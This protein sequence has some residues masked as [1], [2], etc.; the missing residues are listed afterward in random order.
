MIP[1][2][3]FVGKSGSGKTTLIE[4]IISGLRRR[5]WRVATIKHSRHG[6]DIDREGKD[7]WRHRKAGAKMTVMA[8]PEQIAIIE[9]AEKDFEIQD[10]RDKYIHDVD[11]ILTEGFKGN[12]YPKI[13]VFRASLN[14]DMLCSGNDNLIAIASD[15]QIGLG[16]V[17]CIDINNAEDITQLIV[18]LFLNTSDKE[19]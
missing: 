18:D 4:K 16:G 3:S 11:I 6:F 8:S 7:T 2:V 10:L 1:V 14:R 9:D 15:K 17:P 5:G 13:E 19:C 12:E